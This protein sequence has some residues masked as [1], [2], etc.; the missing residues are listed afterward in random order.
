MQS[1]SQEKLQAPDQPAAQ[2]ND[3]QISAASTE[4]THSG[5][6]DDQRH[7]DEPSHNEAN[8]SRGAHMPPGPD[9]SDAGRNLRKLSPVDYKELNSQDHTVAPQK[10][11][12]KRSSRTTDFRHAS[13]FGNVASQTIDVHPDVLRDVPDMLSVKHYMP[14]RRGYWVC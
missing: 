12:P 13:R 11:G 10:T 6:D 5:S 1:N 2:N 9:V 3:S 14:L 7:P 8:N 4:P